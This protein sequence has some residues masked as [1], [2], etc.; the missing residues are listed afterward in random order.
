MTCLRNTPVQLARS[1]IVKAESPAQSM[2]P[3]LIQKGQSMRSNRLR[4]CLVVAALFT[5]TSSASA[6][7]ADPKTD[8]NTAPEKIAQAEPAPAPTP[9]PSAETPT[10]SGPTTPGAR[11]T[12]TEEQLRKMVEEQV[13]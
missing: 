1:D 11:E 9:P 13:A 7:N 3:F 5:G 12:P 4:G 8:D 6:Q 10:S 2:P